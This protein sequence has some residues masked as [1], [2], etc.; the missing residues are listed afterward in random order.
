M[1]RGVIVAASSE[2]AWVVPPADH[3]P[4]EPPARRTSWNAVDLLAATFPEPRWAVPGILAEGLNLL[5]GAPKLGKSWLAMNMCVAVA[6]GGRALGKVKVEQGEALYLAL[7]DPPRRLQQRLRMVL[8][9]DSVPPGLH[10][11]TAWERLTDGGT[12]RLAAWL[13]AHPACRLVVIDVLAKVR[14]QVD[15]RS[16]R[17]DADF[18]AMNMLKS[19]ADHHSVAI[20]VLHH[21]RKAAS[22]DF[23][24]TVSG[25]HGLAGAADA[26]LVMRRARNS[27]DAVLHITGRDVEEAEHAM[28]FDPTRGTW[29]LLDGPA[30]DYDLAD[31][32]RRILDLLRQGGPMRPKQLATALDQDYELVKKT[33]QRMVNDDQLDTD[34]QGHYFPISPVPPVPAVPSAG[35]SAAERDTQHSSLSLAGQ[36]RDRRDTLHSSLSLPEQAPDQR[37]P[38]LRDSRDR[39]DTLDRDTDD[40]A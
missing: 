37:L 17:Y 3:P 22:D 31:T 32:R 35:Q 1:G 24:D 28:R 9:R 10:F 29:T 25:T 21:T 36:V 23:L 38:G 20:L 34:G 12:Q 14:G 13:K 18:Q 11:E 4:D 15:D 8:A 30:S 33:V 16:S 19:L 27:A 40:A 6:A 5:A 39:R 26:V 7:E 2:P